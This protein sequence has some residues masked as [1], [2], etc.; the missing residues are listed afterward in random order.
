MREHKYKYWDG[1]VMSKPQAMV[2]F[3][4]GAEI[5]QVGTM[6]F[7]QFIGLKDKNEVEIYDDDIC[8]TSTGYTF[9]VEMIKFSLGVVNAGCFGYHNYPDCEVIGN[10]YEHG[11]LLDSESPHGK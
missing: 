5:D 6:T 10:I 3:M 9:K 8:R 2:E 7:L 1:K 4:I 11:H